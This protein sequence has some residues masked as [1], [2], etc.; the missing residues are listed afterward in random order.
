MANLLGWALPFLIAA[1]LGPALVD[2]GTFNRNEPVVVAASSSSRQVIERRPEEALA[3][4][5]VKANRPR[6]FNRAAV[7]SFPELG[8][9]RRI[10]LRDAVEGRPPLQT[11]IGVNAEVIE[12][13]PIITSK[14][15]F[16]LDETSMNDDKFLC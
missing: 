12:A 6:A 7:E 14:L 3:Q 10:P 4:T 2:G 16:E 5:P 1:Y 15:A 8:L 11:E 13:T 9:P